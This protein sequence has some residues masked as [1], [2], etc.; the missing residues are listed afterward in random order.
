MDFSVIELYSLFGGL[1]GMILGM[2]ILFRSC[3][4]KEIRIILAITLLVTSFIAVFGTMLYSGK[5]DIIPHLIRIDS[6]FVYLLGPSCFFYVYATFK[7]GFRLRWIYLLHLLPFLANLVEFTPFY[8]SDTNT[9][10]DYYRDLLDAGTVIMPHHYLLKTISLFVY[11]F[12]QVYYFLKY[13]SLKKTNPM[14][15]MTVSWFRIFILI[16]LVSLT[17]LVTDH[18]TGLHIFGDPYRFAILVVTSFL[19]AVTI[20]LLASPQILYGIRNN[21]FLYRSKYSHSRLNEEDKNAILDKLKAYLS[22]K[23]KVYCDAG[24]S[25]PEVARKIEV[26]IHQLSQ[27]I[28]EKTGFN[29]NDYLNIY[30]VEEAKNLLSSTEYDKLTIDAIAHKA[31]FQ[32]KST[33]YNAFKKHTGITPKQFAKTFRSK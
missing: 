6:P 11:L 3:G 15:R 24:L 12:L 28:N 8:L 23:R 27:A 9:K 22:D 14:N 5:A 18:L 1:L 10:L 2:I 16:Q 30:R 7:P 19:Y 17:G 29:F 25:L 32:S 21:G 33:F 26:G 31:G 20:M 13:K 4:K